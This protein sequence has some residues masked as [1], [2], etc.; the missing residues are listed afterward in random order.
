MDIV[1]KTLHQSNAIF[2]TGNV[3][4]DQMSPS[5]TWLSDAYWYFNHVIPVATV[6][7]LLV[8]LVLLLISQHFPR[9]ATGIIVNTT[10]AIMFYV[11]YVFLN[12]PKEVFE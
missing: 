4:G 3:T 7:I 10:L 1:M 5:R 11:L 8:M 6:L 2:L 9:F 12:E